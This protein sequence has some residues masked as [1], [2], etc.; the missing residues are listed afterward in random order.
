[1]HITLKC[2]VKRVKQRPYHLNPK[3]KEKF[4][5]Q[6]DKMLVASIIEP[7]EES[8]WVSPMGVQEKKKKDENHIGG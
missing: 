5:L 6:L 7:V 4:H 1:M 3:C 8:D 2:D